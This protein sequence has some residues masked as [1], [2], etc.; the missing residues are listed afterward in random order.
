[1]LFPGFDNLKR[2]LVTR[3]SRCTK[4]IGILHG[5]LVVFWIASVDGSGDVTFL[6]GLRAGIWLSINRL[7]PRMRRL[8]SAVSALK[9][10]SSF[11]LSCRRLTRSESFFHGG[12]LGSCLRISCDTRNVARNFKVSGV[13]ESSCSFIN[14]GCTSKKNCEAGAASLYLYKEVS[15][16][17]W[18]WQWYLYFRP[19]PVIR[20][21]HMGLPSFE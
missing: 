15:Q 20:R 10:I 11:Q 21:D 4:F 9:A 14:R 12:L 5:F 1:M 17:V 19:N 2:L 7:Y 16:G 8:I 3:E 6:A 18:L 13:V